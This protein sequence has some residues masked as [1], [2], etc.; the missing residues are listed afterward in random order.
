MSLPRPES[1]EVFN[2]H[3]TG[4]QYT[5]F[6]T[7]AIIATDELEVIRFVMPE[8]SS[9]K[10]HCFAG[11]ATLQCVE[12]RLSLTAHGKTSRL[13]ECDMA[14]LAGGAPHSITAEKNTVF[15]MTMVRH[16]AAGKPH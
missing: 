15:L 7:R 5:E 2:V 9:L 8:G 3:P 1:G 11:D 6:F 13:K 10:E 12:G 14:F 16:K 4:E